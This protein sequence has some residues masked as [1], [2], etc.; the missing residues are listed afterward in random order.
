M[1]KLVVLG[2]VVLPTVAFAQGAIKFAIDI[3]NSVIPLVFALAVLF[4]LWNLA[5]FMMAPAEKKDDARTGMIWGVIIL[6]VM[7]SIFG[8]VAIVQ[9]TLTTGD[10]FNDNAKIDT[11]DIE[12]AFGQGN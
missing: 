5:Q 11:P 7:S 1:K 8:I 10:G 4:F 6:V 2:L 12:G 9:D 3:I